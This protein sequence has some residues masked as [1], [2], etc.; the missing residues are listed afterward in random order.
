MSRG[1]KVIEIRAD[2]EFKC[3]QADLLP[4]ILNITAPGEHVLEIERSIRTVKESTRTLQYDLPFKFLL[5]MMTEGNVFASIKNLNALPALDGVSNTL[6]PAA[7]I[8]G[9]SNLDFN[10]L[11]K[12]KY[13]DYMQVFTETKNDISEHTFSA[14]AIYSTGN[15][16][17]SWY[18]LSLTTGKRFIGYQ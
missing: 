5:K 3:L 7:L 12:I 2:G 11:L 14:I 8:T 16:Q 4:C 17:A 18:F 1:L 13:G 6:S 9:K 10:N 15:A